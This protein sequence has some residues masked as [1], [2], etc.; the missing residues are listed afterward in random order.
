MCLNENKYDCRILKCILLENKFKR[1]KYVIYK[2][3][4]MKL[5]KYNL[6]FY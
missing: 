3:C 2:S 4:V 6:Y 1:Y 5:K